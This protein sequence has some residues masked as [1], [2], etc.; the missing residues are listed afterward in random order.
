MKCSSC[1]IKV[2]MAYVIHLALEAKIH[3]FCSRKCLYE[4]I[5]KIKKE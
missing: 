3:Y 5:E 1:G 4:F 2:T